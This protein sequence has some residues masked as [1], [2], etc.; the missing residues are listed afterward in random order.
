MYQLPAEGISLGGAGL[1]KWTG[2]SQRTTFHFP[3]LWWLG[4]VWG[5]AAALLPIVTWG[6]NH[7]QPTHRSSPMWAQN[8]MCLSKNKKT[9][10]H[11]LGEFVNILGMKPNTGYRHFNPN[12]VTSCNKGQ[13]P[14][15][16]ARLRRCNWFAVKAWRVGWITARCFR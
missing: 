16:S 15:K 9:K 6:E 11:H 14:Y 3:S 7:R 12:T 13:N 8:K 4:L 5:S 2:S 10:N 1:L